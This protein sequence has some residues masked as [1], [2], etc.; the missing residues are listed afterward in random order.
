M[1]NSGQS[2][3][4]STLSHELRTPLT[5]IRGF[6]DTLLSSGDKL[7]EDQRRKFLM[8]I[9]EQS[10]RLIKMTENLLSAARESKT[11]LV[12]K[13]FSVRPYV[14]N[15]V[16]MTTKLSKK[17]DFDCRFESGLPDIEADTDKFQQVILNLLENACKYSFDK[18]TIRLKAFQRGDFVCISVEDKGLEI[19]EKDK[20]RIFEKFVR[21]SS[22]L[23]QKTE[24]SGLGL[25][26][27]KQL[28]EK[29]HGKIETVSDAE[30]TVF[31]VCFPVSKYDNVTRRV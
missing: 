25:Y 18:T 15:C 27:T 9:K 2:D 11:E 1:E 20:T 19:P 21:L 8:I 17:N 10:E 28:V 7:T 4:I 5:S 12:F 6:A 22:P 14:E 30:K 26:I 16:N 23:T 13:K 31:T 24:G 3:F 29:M